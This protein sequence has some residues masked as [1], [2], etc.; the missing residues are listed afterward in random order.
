MVA[1]TQKIIPSPPPGM[2]AFTLSDG[3]QLWMPMSLV[4][5]LLPGRHDTVNVYS[6]SR[7]ANAEPISMNFHIAGGWGGKIPPKPAPP[8]NIPPRAMPT[9]PPK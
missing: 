2:R 7:R 4:V 3:S 1:L 6:V 5:E 8:Q 9:E